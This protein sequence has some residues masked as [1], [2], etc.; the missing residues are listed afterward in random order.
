MGDEGVGVHVIHRLMEMDLPPEV[1]LIDGGTAGIDLLPVLERAERL[2]IVDAVCAG[3]KPGSI[4]RFRP[5]QIQENP[6]AAVS[7]HQLSL[8]EVWRAAHLL[9]IQPEAVII[10]VEP[11][12]IAPGV[13]LSQPLREALPRVISAVQAEFRREREGE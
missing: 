3:G 10:G 5:E 11:R 9:G 6:V 13:E 8:G 12:H 4:Y 1:E 2:I 7:L